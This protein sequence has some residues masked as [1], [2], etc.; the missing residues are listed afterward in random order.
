M[1]S[2]S[3]QQRCRTPACNSDT[4][5]YS[6][7]NIHIHI[8]TYGY[9]NMDRNLNTYSLPNRNSDSNINSDTYSDHIQS[10]DTPSSKSATLQIAS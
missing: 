3:F 1:R 8:H 9:G 6:N 4:Y 7:R 2:N 10:I 5:P